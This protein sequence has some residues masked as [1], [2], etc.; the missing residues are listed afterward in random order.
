MLL[1]SSISTIKENPNQL[2]SID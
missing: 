2:G 1:D